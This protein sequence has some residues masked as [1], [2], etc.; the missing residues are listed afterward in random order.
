MNIEVKEKKED[1]DDNQS[2]KD[3]VKKSERK[4]KL[5]KQQEYYKNLKNCSICL[6]KMGRKTIKK[7]KCNHEFHWKCI[8]K[9]ADNHNSCPLCREPIHYPDYFFFSQN[10]NRNYRRLEILLTILSI[11]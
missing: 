11:L 8:D 10:N 5:K 4:Y 1:K 7:I 6:C 2:Y 3:V 9:W